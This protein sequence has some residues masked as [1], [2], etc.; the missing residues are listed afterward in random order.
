MSVATSGSGSVSVTPSGSA[1]DEGTSITVRATPEEHWEFIG[2]SGDVSQ[3]SA[4]IIITMS[5]DITLTATFRSIEEKARTNLD[6][7]TEAYDAFAEDLPPDFEDQ[8]VELADLLGEGGESAAV[9]LTTNASGESEAVAVELIEADEEIGLAT[10]E[11]EATATLRA[12]I[13]E[14]I[15]RAS[16]GERVCH[17]V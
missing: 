9:D 4:A 16:C 12:Q 2:W 1:F 15:G 5:R 14:E 13:D 6:A 7:A 8:V 3:S 11:A 17:R 10:E